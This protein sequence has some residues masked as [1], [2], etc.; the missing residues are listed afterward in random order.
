MASVVSRGAGPVAIDFTKADKQQKK[1]RQTEP[2]PTSG[3][4]L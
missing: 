3:M 4:H 2:L 1:Y